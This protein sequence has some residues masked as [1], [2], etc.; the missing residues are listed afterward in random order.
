[1]WDLEAHDSITEVMRLLKATAQ[2][3]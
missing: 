1:V 3:E 2:S